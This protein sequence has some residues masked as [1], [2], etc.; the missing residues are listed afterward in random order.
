MNAPGTDPVASA[1]AGEEVAIVHEYGGA[2]GLAV[3]ALHPLAMSGRLFERAGDWVEPAGL[4]LLA[5]D[6]PATGPDTAALRVED[7]AATAATVLRRRGLGPVPVLGMSMGGCVALQL[8]LD[9]PELVSRLV[10]ADTTS[11]Y[12]PERVANWEQRAQTAERTPRADLVEFQLDRWF[13]NDF[14]ELDERECARMVEIFT[15]TTAEVHAACCRALGAFDVT[16]RLGE[17]QVPTLVLVGAEDYATPAAMAEALHTGIPGAE[18][19]VLPGVR[20]F[21]LVQ[22]PTAW[23]LIVRQVGSAP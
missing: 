19:T 15:A 12:G 11:D 7:L 23:E 8:A 18:L 16:A 4:T 2:D 9:H 6:L 10:L 21:S 3:L 17:I 20:H 14:R 13:S 5:P 22:S 1:G